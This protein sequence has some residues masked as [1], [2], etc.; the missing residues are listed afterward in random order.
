MRSVL[1]VAGSQ[2]GEIPAI[3]TLNEGALHAQ[4][5]NWYQR[6]G[7]RIERVVDGFVVDLVRGGLLVEIQTGGFAPLR[8]KLELLTRQHRVRLVAPL[9]LVRRIIRLSDE[10]ELLSVRRSPRRGRVEDIFNRLVSI[11]SLL[12]RSH[13]ELEVLLTHQDELRVYRHGKAFRRHGWV[14]SGRR[15]VSV[16][17]CLRITSPDDAARLLPPGLPVLFDTAQLAEAAAIE[18][19]TAQQMTYCLRALGILQTTGKRGNAIVHRRTD[20]VDPRTPIR[21][22]RAS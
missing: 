15:L 6:P 20:R 4:L 21:C 5:K 11:P 19:R 10:G 22:T 7:D 8:R 9:P 18:R 1:E 14:V 13:F 3:G 2:E 16:E 17:Q 12:C